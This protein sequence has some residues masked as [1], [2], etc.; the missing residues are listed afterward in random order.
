MRGFSRVKG[1]DRQIDFTT[2][3][4]FFLCLNLIP[5]F[6]R[7]KYKC[8]RQYRPRKGCKTAKDSPAHRPAPTPKA[9]RTE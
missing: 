8:S 2:I 1:N 5:L 4:V 6:P 3:Y 7:Q 9:T